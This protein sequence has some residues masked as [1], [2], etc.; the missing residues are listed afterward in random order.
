MTPGLF[1]DRDGTLI[2][3]ARYLHD[4]EAIRFLPG[5]VETLRRLAGSY[6]IFLFTNQSGIGRGYYPWE[7]AE[8]VNR[9][10]E[11]RIGPEF[12]FSAV[13]MAPET[14]DRPPVYRKPSP[15]F[16]LETLR[17]FD[18]DPAGCWMFGD[19]VSDARAGI[20]AGIR[21][22]LLESPEALTPDETAFVAR[23][24]IPILPGL[25]ALARILP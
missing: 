1:F 16:I 25:P 12:H 3:E 14:P 5:V 20:R 6:R 8:A 4:P 13:C 21:S 2:E 23:H 11:R 18:L 15:R 19:R 24:S 7:A 10:M 9:R 22:A 17:D